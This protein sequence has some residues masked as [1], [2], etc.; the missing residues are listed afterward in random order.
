MFSN[1][2]VS[3]NTI[4]YDRKSFAKSYIL[5]VSEIINS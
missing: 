5:I 4:E 2:F 1:N 3:L